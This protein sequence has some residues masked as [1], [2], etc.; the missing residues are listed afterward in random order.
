VGTL[1]FSEIQL[2]VNFWLAAKILWLMQ[3]FLRE[4]TSNED[5]FAPQMLLNLVS[6]E[7]LELGES[8]LH[9]MNGASAVDELLD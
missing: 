7:E 4:E 8:L 6:M 5:L 2:E 3:R 9:L 1:G